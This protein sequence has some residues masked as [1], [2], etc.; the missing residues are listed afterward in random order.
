MAC[1]S[2]PNLTNVSLIYV[3]DGSNPKNF[4]TSENK[5]EDRGRGR[6]RRKK[7][8]CNV[9]GGSNRD[10][11]K[12]RG[13]FTM[14]GSDDYISV[15]EVD[16]LSGLSAFTICA[17]IYPTTS[18]NFWIVSKGINGSDNREYG[19]YLNS[20]SKAEV[21]IYDESE[22]LYTT[23]TSGS[24]LAANQWHFVTATFD[25]SNLQVTAN[26]LSKGASQASTVVME[27]LSAPL[28]IGR[29]H[30]SSSTDYANG[31]IAA[32][33]IYDAALSEEELKEIYNKKRAKFQGR[34][35]IVAST[36]TG[37]EDVDEQA[38]Q[39][40]QA[41][42]L[43]NRIQLNITT[44]VNIT[45]DWGD[46]STDTYSTSSSQIHTYSSGGDKTIKVY[47]TINGSEIF[48]GNSVKSISSIGSWLTGRTSFYRLF[49]N[50]TN[51]N[52]DISSWDT[53][54]ITNFQEMFLNASSFNQNIGSWDTSSV[55]TMYR[56]FRGA[57][58]F[59]QDIGGWNTGSVNNFRE[60][61]FN[62]DA[63]DQDISTWDF[64]GCNGE[65]DLRDFFRS[66]TGLST[67]NYD[68]LLS[69][70]RSQVGSMNFNGDDMIVHMGGS[71]RS[72]SGSSDRSWLISEHDWSI[73]DGG[74]A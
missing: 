67:S 42:S 10:E 38:L 44:S 16:D 29:S 28:H 51:F 55:T 19:L 59:N 54:N 33:Y 72:S 31:Y 30:G 26:L 47:G 45:V 65:N 3:M 61:F 73:S 20:D 12:G 69:R 41:A 60:M 27:E 22:G 34:A 64:R 8:R 68:A 49:Y 7:R 52:S 14:D 74:S 2:G 71:T 39:F 1:K 25:G 13:S 66:A 23:S 15:D 53:S 5:V 24:A 62:A 46:G 36:G 56:M 11:D 32:V 17:W 35:A 37:G 4:S 18:S 70:W 9:S 6:K 50:N 21:I 48:D 58:S 57:T 40:V 43:Y 63:F